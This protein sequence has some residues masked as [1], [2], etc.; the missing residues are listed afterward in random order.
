MTA[1]ST[2]RR[3]SGLTF[4]EPLTTLDTV[5]RETPARDATSS[6]VVPLRRPRVARANSVSS[7]GCESALTLMEDHNRPCQESALTFAHGRGRRRGPWTRAGGG[8]SPD[9]CGPATN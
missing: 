8:A 1:A 3:T 4:G 6:R 5:A 9:P 7:A 2:A